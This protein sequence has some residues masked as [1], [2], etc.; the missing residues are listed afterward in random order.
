M[1]FITFLVILANIQRVL[2]GITKGKILQG[3]LERE[4]MAGA[5]I[6]FSKMSCEFLHAISVLPNTLQK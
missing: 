4:T 5:G 6:P 3:I 1:I 2:L